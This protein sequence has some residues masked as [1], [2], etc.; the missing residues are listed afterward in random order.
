MSG[1]E[2][3]GEQPAF[4]TPRRGPG[5]AVLVV[6][7]RALLG[8]RRLGTV[9]NLPKGWGVR[10]GFESGLNSIEGFCSAR[11]GCNFGRLSLRSAGSVPALL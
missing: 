9:H 6:G 4:L 5:E 1:G 2:I 3:H 8:N 7:W 10:Y 11:R